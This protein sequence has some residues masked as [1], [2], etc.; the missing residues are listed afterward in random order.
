MRS[1]L[2]LQLCEL[3][4]IGVQYGAVK[5]LLELLRAGEAY[6]PVLI[7]G[8]VAGHGNKGPLAS[9]DDPHALDGEAR[10]TEASAS[11]PP[12]GCRL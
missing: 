2:P 6:V 11:L 1:L 12:S 9:V 8:F 10:L 5:L 3:L 4:L 7:S